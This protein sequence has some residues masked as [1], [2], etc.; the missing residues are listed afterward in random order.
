MISIVIPV[1]NKSHFTESCLKDLVLLN[2]DNEII[3]IDNNSTDDTE[4]VV[5][6]FEKVKYHK[7]DK[8]YGFGKACN[9]GYKFSKYNNVLFLNNDIRVES[10]FNN[11]TKELEESCD[12]GLV[13]PTMGLLNDRLEF[14]KEE[15]ANLHGNSYMSGWCLASS[16]ENFEKLNL[17]DKENPEIFAEKYFCYFE[18]T[19]LSFRARE[20]QINFILKNVPVM[21]F[22]MQTTSQLNVSKLYHDSK[23]IFFNDWGNKL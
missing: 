4:N 19:D 13:G 12:Y 16:K 7:L 5:N 20:K 14:V 8:N 15:N 23:K 21:H 10:N 11:W 1:F 2:D 18:D 3:V 22:K 9:I 17:R 6:K